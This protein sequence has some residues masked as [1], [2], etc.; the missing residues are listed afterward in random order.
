MARALVAH[1]APGG[2]VG[3]ADAGTSVWAALDTASPTLSDTR[4]AVRL[5]VPPV[6]ESPTAE[7]RVNATLLAA[8]T[9]DERFLVSQTER[10]ALA[11][12]DEDA[13]IELHQRTRRARDKYVGQYR[14]GASARVPAK[15]ARGQARPANER[16]A[17]RA[18]AFEEALARVSR[19][20]GALAQAASRELRAERLAAA[21]SGRSGASAGGAGRGAGSAGP[22]GD[23][24][25]AP[26]GDRAL[27]G[28]RTERR[29]AQTT[30]MGARRQA[31]RDST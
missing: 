16:A 31:K 28:P 8:L 15:G 22:G 17:L 1:E 24:S 11:E 29:R 21:R 27:R 19:R 6:P 10:D 30:A 26:Q 23:Q 14:R 25:P 7:V 3:R 5:R 20:L 13:V 18:E 2:L 9:P 4:A 12:L